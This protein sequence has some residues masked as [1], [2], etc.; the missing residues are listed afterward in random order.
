MSDQRTPRVEAL[1]LEA[2]E[3]APDEREDLLSRVAQDDPA[4]AAEVSIG[5]RARS[6]RIT[7]VVSTIDRRPRIW[8]A[9]IS[10]R[11]RRANCPFSIFSF[12]R[13]AHQQGVWAF[14]RTTPADA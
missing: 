10:W 9:L 8:H 14:A 5:C 11:V 6:I 1:F 2:S 4:V 7:Y 3:L 13:R 12:L